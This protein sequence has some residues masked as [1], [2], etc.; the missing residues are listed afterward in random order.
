MNQSELPSGQVIRVAV[1][2]GADSEFDYLLPEG[3]G[4]IAQGQRVEVPFGKN[5]KRIAAF[6]VKVITDQ[7]EIHKS[8]QFRLKTVK[9]ILDPVS[10]LDPQQ[11]GLA[12]WIAEYYVCPIGQVLAAMVP[13]A[14]KKDAGAKTEQYIYL[15]QTKN[16]EFAAVKRP[17]Q[18]AIIDHLLTLEIFD[19]SKALEKK[20]LLRQVSCTVA[21]LK[22]LI[23][24]G[25]VGVVSRRVV[26]T[27]PA[28]D[29]ALGSVK[30]KAPI[31][32]PLAR[33]GKYFFF[34][35]SLPNKKIG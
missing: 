33:G 4:A 35:S 15:D 28:S 24:K 1:N 32:A 29:P 5:N 31:L 19:E 23:R 18:R 3:M 22:G 30:P 12:H 17:K 20:S 21:V 10:L 25:L 2:T 6:V 8:K 27:L 14:V 26:W 9:A 16:N 13:A 11:M 34:C 7:D